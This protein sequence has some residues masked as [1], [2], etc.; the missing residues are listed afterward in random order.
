MNILITGGTGFLGGYLIKETA[1]QYE[2]VYIVSRKGQ[3]SKFSEFP[4][5]KCIKGDVTH[6]EVLAI[7]GDERSELLSSID[8]V[9]HAAPFTILVHLTLIV[10]YKTLS[11]HKTFS[12]F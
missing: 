9:V 1:S 8:I 2:N 5:V 12:I 10:S 6:L 7:E 11:V 4:N 3:L